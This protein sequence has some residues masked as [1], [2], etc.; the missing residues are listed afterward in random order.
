MLRLRGSYFI[1]LDFESWVEHDL[2]NLPAT[3]PNC[4]ALGKLLR[5]Y[6]KVALER[7]SGL[8]E[9]ISV[10]ALTIV[11]LWV[12]IDLIVCRFLPLMESFT[13]EIPVDFLQPLLLPHFS[14]ME[15]LSAIEKYLISRH[16]ESKATNSSHFSD[17][18]P[19]SFSVQ[20]MQCSTLHRE[21][22]EE[23]EMKASTIREGKKDEW[24][25]KTA[26]YERLQQSAKS[27]EHTCDKGVGRG[28]S[29]RNLCNR[30]LLDVEVSS[31]AIETH[32]WPL[33][34]DP[35]ICKAAVFELQCPP[36]YGTWRDVTWV[37]VQDL[38]VQ[39]SLAAAKSFGEMLSYEPL[40]AWRSGI[41]NEITLGSSL[42]LSQRHITAE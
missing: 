36:T 5:A 27:T 34:E 8:P 1:L 25:L 6:M 40:K 23:I 18:C 13:P 31:V 24:R 11:E 29:Q 7:Y 38:G 42:S 10:M 37:I 21:L 3:S 39:E 12:A 4:I 32:E 30:C 15:R 28:Q 16:R 9:Q 41:R 2:K 17:P 22:R 35:I 33:P 20:Y 26:W 14:Q 19:S